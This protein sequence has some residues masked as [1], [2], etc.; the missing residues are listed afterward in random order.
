MRDECS[1]GLRIPAWLAQL[2][3]EVERQTSLERE[4]RGGEGDGPVAVQ[5]LPDPELAREIRRWEMAEHEREISHLV[6]ESEG[7]RLL[8]ERLQPDA[9][10]GRRQ[11]LTAKRGGEDRRR[12]R[13]ETRPP[14]V[15]RKE[16]AAE[17]A[18]GG[19]KVSLWEACGKVAKRYGCHARTIYNDVKRAG[20]GE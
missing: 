10:V 4:A 13:E 6:E 9:E 11:R 2:G 19:G 12:R 20:E 16:V 5:F 8:A 7:R 18:R 15:I 3:E 14:E 1:D 17:I